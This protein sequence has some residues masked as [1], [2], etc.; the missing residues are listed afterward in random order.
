[1]GKAQLDARIVMEVVRLGTFSQATA[2]AAGA[3]ALAS[4]AAPIVVVLERLTKFELL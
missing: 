3:A 2:I 4:T 1:M